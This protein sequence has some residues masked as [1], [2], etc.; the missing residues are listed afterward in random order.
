MA[1]FARAARTCSSKDVKQF[2]LKS[3]IANRILRKYSRGMNLRRVGNVKL[4][5]PS[6]SI[7]VEE[8]Q[9]KIL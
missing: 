7:H 6:Q 3:V 8:D 4:T 9:L 1:E 5:A 2:G